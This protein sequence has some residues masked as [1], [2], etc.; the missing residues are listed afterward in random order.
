VVSGPRH[1]REDFR[2]KE[3]IGSRG[4]DDIAGRQQLDLA[5]IGQD[6]F[7]LYRQAIFQRSAVSI[8]RFGQ[9][10]VN[11]GCFP[12]L[13]VVPAEALT[14]TCPALMSGRSLVCVVPGP[15][16]AAAV[17]STLLDA[18]ST[19]CP[20]TLLRRHPNAVLY[21]DPGSSAELPVA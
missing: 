8:G 11:D 21:L 18:I 1:R 16:K 20:A 9:Q 14:L 4:F 15:R 13:E 7:G 17:R 2:F 19:A 6:D 5:D 10:Q 3:A 12:S